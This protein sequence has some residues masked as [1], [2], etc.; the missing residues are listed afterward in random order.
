MKIRVL[1][2]QS[3]MIVSMASVAVAHNGR[4][5]DVQIHNDQLF[6]QGYLSGTNPTDDQ[7]GIVRPYFNALHDHWGN[8]GG[9]AIASLPGFDINTSDIFSP[10]E[11][12]IRLAG[13]NLILT[14]TGSGKWHN[15]SGGH[16][17]HGGEGE[18][19]PTLMPLDASEIINVGYDVQDDI[20]TDSLGSFALAEDIRGPVSDIDLQYSIL[21]NPTNTLYYI[22]WQ[23]STDA[24]GI[25]DSDP[26]YTIL[27]PDPDA[28]DG[29]HHPS[30]ALESH[31]GISSVPEPSTIAAI[32]L[33]AIGAAT[34]RRRR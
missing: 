5:F 25:A 3:L 8:V 10:P 30:L 34:R 26:I 20:G 19:M 29:L 28:T 22:Q 9:V 32:A 4:R 1:F 18:G 14:M 12:V 17:G 31:F 13:H 6:A 7:G 27:S 23:L 21:L 24:P 11:T 16:G 33:G 15:P 2:L